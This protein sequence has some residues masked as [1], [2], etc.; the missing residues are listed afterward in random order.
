MGRLFKTLLVALVLFT[1][2]PCLSATLYIPH[3]TAHD[4]SWKSILEI[5]NPGTA[6]SAYTLTLY[7]NAGSKI[8]GPTTHKIWTG[9][10]STKDLKSL[11]PG[12]ASGEIT[13]NNGLLKFR[14][15]YEHLSGGGVAEF[16]LTSSTFSQLYFYF[17]NFL[18]YPFGFVDWKG[19]ALMNAGTSSSTVTL[20]AFGNG[21]V[22]RTASLSLPAKSRTPLL[23]SSLFPGVNELHIDR[24]TALATNGKLV[25]ITIAGDPQFARLL[26]TKAAPAPTDSGEIYIPHI[27][28][29]DIDWLDRLQIDNVGTSKGSF[30][31]EFFDQA[32]ARIFGPST[33]SIDPLK[34]T[35]YNIKAFK[36]N[37]TSGRISYTGNLNFRLAYQKNYVL[38]A[39]AEF[40]LTQAT[41]RDLQ[42]LF[43]S[44]TKIV[45]WKG[46]A[47]VNGGSSDVQVNIYC[48]AGSKTYGPVTKVIPARTRLV[49]FHD[50]WFPQ[51]STGAVARMR[52]TA[53]SPVLAG[54]TISGD[55][56]GTKMLSTLALP[57][58]SSS[59]ASGSTDFP[60]TTNAD[61]VK[62]IIAMGNA[63]A[64]LYADL[65][66]LF[67]EGAT[68][69][70]FASHVQFKD[71]YY[72]NFADSIA[73]VLQTKA[74]YDKAI[75]YMS[76]TTVKDPAVQYRS[77]LQA[78]GVFGSIK[79]FFY[80]WAW[81]SGKRAATKINTNYSALS[82]NVQQQLLQEA[83]QKFG[84]KVGST[85]AEFRQKLKNNE[86]TAEAHQL[87]NLFYHSFAGLESGK[88]YSDAAADNKNRPIDVAY[89]EGG[90]GVQKGLDVVESAGTTIVGSKLPDFTDGY[91]KA[92]DT[93]TKI[94][95]VYEGDYQG[96]AT[97]AAKNA[98]KDKAGDF[99]KDK[100]GLGDT[101]AGEAA[102]LIADSVEQT[103]K[104]T[105]AA[106]QDNDS[107]FLDDI[108]DWGWSYISPAF[109]DTLDPSE[110]LSVISLPDNIDLPLVIGL[111]SGEGGQ[112][113]LPLPPG[114]YDATV[115]AEDDTSDVPDVQAK[116]G[117]GTVVPVDG[118]MEDTGPQTYSLSATASPANPAPGVGTVT[119]TARV[120][121]PTA[122]LTIL[123]S[124]S[125]TD[126]YSKSST[127][128][129]SAAGT[130][131][132]YIKGTDEA[133]VRDTVRVT[134][135]ETGKTITFSYVF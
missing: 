46:I 103:V 28:G 97:D 34:Y 84:T 81:G 10:Y 124:V 23:L 27:T 96:L 9:S 119:V 108:V 106:N 49:G 15:A 91:D 98:I 71:Q 40:N 133:G 32:G 99:L 132:F 86:L 55:D 93:I 67:S 12:A 126:G 122:G 73:R 20:Q 116:P 113:K 48:S 115:V 128:K 66:N 64:G 74:V 56:D 50:T 39:V 13:T 135:Q 24:V 57:Y 36:K 26:F 120:S 129:T 5:D 17:P 94:N 78:R 123:F 43:A 60:V 102:D 29:G 130:A 38:G 107:S 77:H 95:Q 110:I 19:I 111:L 21:K 112:D 3:I 25:G 35:S 52:V 44:F 58:G 118:S 101:A 51:L 105:L 63:Q 127:V 45:Q 1:A 117:E 6:P 41:Q 7:N 121:P 72:S 8:Y 14:I 114:S 104:T 59:G 62:A 11:A 87:H 65:L 61:A 125:G 75:S 30:S 79:N 33:F 131:N 42:F 82:A 92:K 80:D 53:P 100:L 83:Q 109:P 37:A 16:D 89:E 68:K 2:S 134:L 47:V 4:P 31:L 70:L 69:P 22:L 18:D 88:S 85:P 54:I 90:E 76:S